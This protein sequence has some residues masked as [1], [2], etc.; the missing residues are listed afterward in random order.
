[1]ASVVVKCIDG[2]PKQ[3][4]NL[5]A[6][7]PSPE[8]IKSKLIHIDEKIFEIS[9]QITELEA[10]HEKFIQDAQNAINSESARLINQILGTSEADVAPID[11]S[12]LIA[13]R[14]RIEQALKALKNELIE[15][16]TQQTQ[17][18]QC[19]INP[20]RNHMITLIAESSFCRDARCVVCFDLSALVVIDL[21]CTKIRQETGRPIC[22]GGSICMRC[23][24]IWF[25]FNHPRK[26][27]KCI[28]CRNTSP[29]LGNPV[30]QFIFDLPRALYVDSFLK[31]ESE[32]FETLY[33]RQLKPV[34]CNCGKD[35][36]TICDLQQHIHNECPNAFVACNN[37]A[38]YM[39][40]S[41]IHNTDGCQMCRPEINTDIIQTI[42]NDENDPWTTATDQ[43]W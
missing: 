24:P 15:L 5:I 8:I 37:C 41:T 21:P 2:H 28:V 3:T 12:V 16:E 4:K 26:P 32:A 23:A 43:G 7:H 34:Q 35:Y 42:P 33:N 1:M 38:R 17:Y 13:E 30:T 36:D 25:D 31:R 10:E 19:H 22:P 9:H 40:R 18:V 6:E 27:A 39:P 11:S 14:N 29:K 20:I